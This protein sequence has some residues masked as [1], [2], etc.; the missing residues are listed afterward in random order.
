[1]TAPHDDQRDPQLAALLQATVDA[2]PLRP[3]FHDELEARLRSADSAA[4]RVPPLRRR[5]TTRRVLAAA[6]VVA[7]AAVFAFAILPA[8]RS[9]DAATAGDVLAAM[10]AA[11]GGAQTVRLHVITNTSTIA[12][13]KAV[14]EDRSTDETDLTMSITGDS[15]VHLTSSQTRKDGEGAWRTTGSART[16]SYD[17]ARHEA[18]AFGSDARRGT[19]IR[20]PAWAS[21]TAPLS[22]S[23]DAY[24]V[25]S[26][27]LRAALAETDP[28]RPVHETSYLG[29]PAWRGVFTVKE[30]W[31]MD[32]EIPVAFHWD[33]TVD[34]A[35]GLL[36]SAS[37]RMEA[38]GKPVPTTWELRV[39]DMTLD[40][41]LEP[42]WQLPTGPGRKVDDHRRGD[43]LRHAGRSGRS[44]L[45][46]TAAHPPVGAGRLPAD[47]RGQR[48][49]RR[50]PGRTRT[51]GRRTTCPLWSSAATATY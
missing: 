29:R 4:T 16:E 39:A 12:G 35:T 14:S 20:R 51:T 30:Q 33:V 17:Q 27:I 31:G 36:M 9:D 2:P 22:E 34:Q 49:L 28:S 41:K 45:A 3:G 18:R 32:N 24:S 50:R 15:L 13:G 46:D 6:A 1:M 11:S 8:V 21:G 10:T 48:R 26:A 7:A 38:K 47:R 37:Y 5:L 44:I 23:A 40:P 42:D 19:T 43:P 25:L